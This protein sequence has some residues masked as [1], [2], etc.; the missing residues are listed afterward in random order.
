MFKQ[1]TYPA[2][3]VAPVVGELVQA[4]EE[5]AILLEPE[6]FDQLSKQSQDIMLKVMHFMVIMRLTGG[7]LGALFTDADADAD[8]D[9]D[10]DTEGGCR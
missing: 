7:I 10:T 5:C 8:V 1:E 3:K 6:Q 2:D 4:L 9:T